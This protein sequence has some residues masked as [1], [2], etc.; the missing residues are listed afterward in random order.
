MF[1]CLGSVPSLKPIWR[2]TG[3]RADGDLVDDIF[4]HLARAA[5]ASVLTR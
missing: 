1:V 3:P 5:R 4:D 2:L